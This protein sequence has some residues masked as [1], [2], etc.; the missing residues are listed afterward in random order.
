MMNP[1]KNILLEKAYQNVKDLVI[2]GAIPLTSADQIIA[3]TISGFGTTSDEKLVSLKNFTELLQ[4]QRKQ[5]EGLEFNW[6]FSP[7]IRQ[8]LSE[9]NVAVFSDDVHAEITV[10]SE[11]IQIYV[12]LTLVFE[13]L[14]NSWK[15]VH[16]HA[17]KP[18]NVESVTDTFGIENWKQKIDQL[19]IIVAERTSELLEKNRE[20]EIEAALE[21]VRSVALGLKKSDELLD[22]VEVLYH[23]LFSLGF[24]NIRNTIIDIHTDEKGGFLDYDY[25]PEMGRSKTQMNYYDDPVIEKQ[26]KQIGNSVDGFFEIILEGKD[27]EDLKALRIKNGEEVDDRLNKIDQLTYNLYSFGAGEIGISSFGLLDENQ[28]LVLQR[29]KNVF[30]FA[31]NR[32]SELREA[33][34]RIREAQIET[35]LEKVRS[36]TMSMQHSEELA[37]TSVVVFKELVTLGINPNRLF[38]GLIE[39]NNNDIEAWVSNADGSEIGGHFTLNTEENASTKKMY[40]AWNQKKSSLTLEMMGEELQNY[41]QYLS[42]KMN[43]PYQSRY[44]QT[45]RIQTLAFFNQGV[46]GMVSKEIQPESSTQLLERFAAVFNLTYTRFNDLKIAEAQSLKAEKD[47]RSIKK[48]RKDAEKSLEELQITQKQLIQSEK[49]ASL[50]ELTAGI[51]HEIQ[52]PLNFVNNFSEVSAELLAEMQEEIDKGNFEEAKFLL[53]DVTQNLEK[54]NNHGKRADAIVKGMLQHSRSSNG[55]K[56]P[57]DLNLLCDEY[58]RLS[59]HGLRAKDKKFNATINTDFDENIG[60]IPL[61]QQDFGRV[62]L[63]LLTNAFYAVTE[64]NALNIENYKPTVSI[65]TKKAKH[66]IIIKVSDNGN[67]IPPEVKSKIFQPFFSTKPTGKGTGLGLSMSYDIITKGHNGELKVNSEVNKGTEFI[68]QLVINEDSHKLH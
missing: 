55:I 20:L 68:I 45:R 32:Y 47:L 28:K 57:C 17:S 59:Y 3:D 4:S 1:A 9:G 27:L 67:G 51:A 13:F 24:T 41:F 14:E 23:Q 65:A 34:D 39:K 49:M 5:S 7:L 53:T 37:K 29:F 11:I 66:K 48:A 36:R 8:F 44:S 63:N 62:I 12:R 52:N 10:E 31:Y 50:G 43:V 19:E 58:L 22:I 18:E 46:I 21:K 16:L 38:I 6:S 26:F 42:L 61:I 30:S 35:A 15:L 56:E 2:K 54:I 40:D 33:E 64:K 25:S 60:E